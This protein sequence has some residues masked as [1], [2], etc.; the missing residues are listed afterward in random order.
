MEI[1]KLPLAVR[2]FRIRRVFNPGEFS[3]KK[4]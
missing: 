3:T 2:T 4:K 1:L